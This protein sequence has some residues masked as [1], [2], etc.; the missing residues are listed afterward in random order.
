MRTSL[1]NDL[2]VA[3]YGDVEIRQNFFGLFK[4]FRL[5]ASQIYFLAHAL[6]E[7]GADQKRGDSK[8]STCDI[9]CSIK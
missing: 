3:G 2:H 6:T 4:Y 9:M 1:G 8:K 5:A 7:A